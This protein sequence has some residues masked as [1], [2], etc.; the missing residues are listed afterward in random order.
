MEIKKHAIILGVIESLNEHESWTGKTHVQKALWL[1]SAVGDIEVPFRFVLY[2][3]GPY[4]FDVEEESEQM[5]GYAAVTVDTI[6]GM[7]VSLHA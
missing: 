7:G 5:K 6:P 4:S 1:L 2:K 3:H